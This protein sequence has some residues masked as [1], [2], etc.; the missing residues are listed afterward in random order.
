MRKIR[1]NLIL[2]VGL[3]CLFFFSSG[4][5]FTDGKTTSSFVSN[6]SCSASAGS[7]T[8]AFKGQVYPI[9]KSRCAGCHAVSQRPLM[10]N[11]DLN[12]AMTA[13]QSYIDANS[14]Q[15]SALVTFSRNGHCGSLPCQQDPTS[16]ISAI[17]AW[18]SNSPTSC[19]SAPADP[20]LNNS[21]GPQSLT[22]A[23]AIAYPLPLAT[24][25]GMDRVY[26]TMRW[27]LGSVSPQ[28]PDLNGAVFEVQI[29]QFTLANATGPASYRLREPRLATPNS[30][31]HVQGIKIF[32]NGSYV[33]QANEF[34]NANV[35]VAPVTP[36][37][38]PVLPFPILSSMDII[39]MAQDPKTDTLAFGFDV[40]SKST[41]PFCKNPAIFQT[42]VLPVLQ[43]NCVGCH[44]GT[45]AP[46]GGRFLMVGDLNTVCAQSLQ[47]VDLKNPTGSPLITNPT[48]Q[49]NGH[50]WIS[51]FRNIQPF[52]DWI[53]SEN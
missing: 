51:T 39:M 24:D 22:L 25:P 6:T 13:A 30:A 8:S 48:L 31:I 27:D 21:S 28:N 26:T 32:L 20:S 3:S 52:I 10:A 34:G 41:T 36:P 15:N 14:L 11:D 43:Q 49:T 42:N 40:L 12:Q 29:Q 53:Q 37:W 38:A 9:L 1:L 19:A 23:Q 18:K 50:D 17:S 44:N 46:G 2:I 35:I 7:N 33:P 47:R 16:L 45:N 5:I 4:C